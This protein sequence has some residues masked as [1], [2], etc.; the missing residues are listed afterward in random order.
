MDSG[1]A[2]YIQNRNLKLAAV[3]KNE[4]LTAKLREKEAQVGRLKTE[5]ES[6]SASLKKTQQEVV[7]KHLKLSA[8]R[9]ARDRVK[10]PPR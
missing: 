10:A 9:P 4:F 2:A 3:G 7:K 8:L 6:L 1:R 5:I